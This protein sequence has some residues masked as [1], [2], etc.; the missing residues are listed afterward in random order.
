MDWESEMRSHLKYFPTALVCED[1]MLTAATIDSIFADHGIA[2]ATFGSCKSSLHWLYDRLPTVSFLDVQ[3]SD[4][5]C[6]PVARRLRHLGV[7]FVFFSGYDRSDFPDIG[8]FNHVDWFCKPMPL[9]VL[10]DVAK[11]RSQ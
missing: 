7:P 11:I 8:E 3:L 10:V 1:D 4:G 6:F 9:D 5:L 2:V